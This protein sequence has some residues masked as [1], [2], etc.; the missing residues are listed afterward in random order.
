MR[1][2]E[3]AKTARDEISG[4]ELCGFGWW[5]VCGKFDDEWAIEQL[6]R[7]LRI[8]GYVEPDFQVVGRLAEL[9]PQA[10]SKAVACLGMLVEGDEDGWRIGGW[11]QE[12][13]TILATVLEKGDEGEIGRVLAFPQRFGRSHFHGLGRHH[14]LPLGMPYSAYQQGPDGAIEGGQAEGAAEQVT[15]VG[16]PGQV[17]G[18]YAKDKHGGR[19]DP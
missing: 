1:R 9:A 19:G 12:A 3:A 8:A 2:L 15:L 14:V 7:A 17:V 16:S 11:S 18:A 10:P 13:H 5:F 6:E 4:G